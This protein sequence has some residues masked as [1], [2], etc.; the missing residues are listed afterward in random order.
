MRKA[1]FVFALFIVSSAF[2]EDVTITSKVTKDGKTDTVTNYMTSERARFSQPD[3]GT[4][5]VDF[6]TGDITIVNAKK[7]QYS[8]MTQKELDDAAAQMKETMESPEMKEAQERM[9]NLPPD[10]KAKMESMMGGMFKADVQKTGESRTIAGLRCEVW[11]VNIGT[12]SQSQQCLTQD[13]KFPP[14]AWDRFKKATDTMKTMA[15]AMGPMAKNM[16]S[17]REELAKAKGFPLAN[18]TTTSIMGNKSVSTTEVTSIKYGPVPANAFDIPAGY[19]KVDS[20]MKNM[21]KKRS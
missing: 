13:V 8:V 14:Q 20:P 1:T 3:G 6:K 10:V 21:G 18:T 9:K 7:Q 12:M 15:G 2:A 19:T 17:M 5:I 4:F 16:A 11:N